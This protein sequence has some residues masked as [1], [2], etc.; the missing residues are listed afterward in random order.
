MS[1]A[2]NVGQNYSKNGWPT[3]PSRIWE[4]LNI[5]E[6]QQQIKMTFTMTWRAD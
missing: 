4:R 5:S 2:Q 6:R 1:L 3:E